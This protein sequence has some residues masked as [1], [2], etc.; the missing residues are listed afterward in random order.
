[1]SEPINTNSR[2]LSDN[3]KDRVLKDLSDL[4]PNDGKSVF[5]RTNDSL[6]V[7]QTI[8]QP[9]SD[10]INEMIPQRGVVV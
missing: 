8:A 4:L 9:A 3:V 10:P 7:A 5:S 2:K 1:M 6:G